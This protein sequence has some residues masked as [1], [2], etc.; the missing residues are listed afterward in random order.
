MFLLSGVLCL[1]EFDH[2]KGKIKICARIQG[3]ASG[4]SFLV[5]LL[6]D[7]LNDRVLF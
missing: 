7:S 4:S 2:K 5:G 6:M 1:W 3:E